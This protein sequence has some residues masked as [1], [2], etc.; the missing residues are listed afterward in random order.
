MIFPGNVGSEDVRNLDKKSLAALIVGDTD[1]DE[2]AFE[3]LSSMIREEEAFSV[4][5]FTSY[6]QFR[7]VS[8]HVKKG[9]IVGLA[10]LRGSGRTEIFKSIV[11]INPFD[12]GEIRVEGKR[13]RYSSPAAA[14]ADGI[15]Y[16]TE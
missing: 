1:Y 14:G 7:D 4:D 9:E 13:R 11:G 6:G 5:N 8:L 15:V 3:D 12:E 16:L 2:L 10:G